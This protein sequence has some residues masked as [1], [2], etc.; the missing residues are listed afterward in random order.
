[1]N[2]VNRNKLEVITFISSYVK[3]INAKN[4]KGETA[5]SLAVANNSPEI[6]EF[7]IGKNADV[8]VLDANGNHLGYYLLQSYNSKNRDA[9]ETKLNMLQS[10]GLDITLAQKDGNT[11][12]HLALDKN[13]LEL[14]KR[15]QKFNVDINAKNNEGLTALHKAAMKAS[16]TEVLKYLISIG[17]D[18]S[19]TTD[20]EETVYDLA[21]ENELL[22]QKNIAIDFLK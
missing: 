12:C 8:N 17:A 21:S 1:M 7:L 4:K 22:S 6:V 13:D 11:L 15:I 10:K 5:L 16:D 19:I 20:F 14:L 18:K 9:F 2:A 3:D